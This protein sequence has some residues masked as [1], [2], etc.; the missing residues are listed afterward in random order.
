MCSPRSPAERRSAYSSRAF[1]QEPNVLILDEP[2]N[3]LDIR[4]QFDIL[5][6][7]RGR[8]VTVIAALHD[9]NM[10]AQ[11]CSTLAV[12]LDGTIAC[13]G[14]PDE[15]LTTTN[16]AKWYGVGAYVVAHPRTGVPQIIFDDQV[17]Q[18]ISEEEHS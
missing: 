8:G 3:H 4:H 6:A 10:A 14:P 17:P 12:V 16:I 15:L 9:L 7:A 13:I 5:G 18:A 2:T 1:A 11:Y